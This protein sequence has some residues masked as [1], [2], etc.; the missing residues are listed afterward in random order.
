MEKIG[1]YLGSLQVGSF[2]QSFI[3][4]FIYWLIHSFIN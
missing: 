3:Q 2:I 4:F 1:Q